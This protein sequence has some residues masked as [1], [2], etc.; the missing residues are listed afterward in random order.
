[1]LYIIDCVDKPGS[2]AVRSAN[3]AEHL[4]YLEALGDRLHAAGPTLSEDGQSMT[5]SLLIIDF[6]DRAEAEGFC[7]G[8]PYAKAGLFQSVTIRPWRRVLPRG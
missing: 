4:A 5:G 7:A 1:M 6:A 3:R 8:D 2:A